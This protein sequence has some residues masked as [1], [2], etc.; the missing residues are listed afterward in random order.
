MDGR[1]IMRITII[2]RPPIHCVRLLQNSIEYG[3]IS[4][5]FRIEEPVVEKPEVDSKKALIND[6]IVPLIR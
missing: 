6:G 5:F 3:R 1:I 4:T 2:P